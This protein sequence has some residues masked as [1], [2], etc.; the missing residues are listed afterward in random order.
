MP[1]G[2]VL[3]KVNTVDHAAVVEFY[4]Q[5]LKPLGN[6]KLSTM[7]NGWVVFGSKG[8]EWVV[9]IASTESE[10]KAHVAFVAPDRASVDAFH[11]TAVAAG[12]K[13]HGA[14]GFR[15]Q[16]HPN[17]YGAFVLDPLGNNIEAGCMTPSDQGEL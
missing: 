10:T 16:I 8:P 15:P 5:A 7:P 11:A 2:H 13:D 6:E 17:Y 12:G 14:P 3:L 9:G 4:T 1:I